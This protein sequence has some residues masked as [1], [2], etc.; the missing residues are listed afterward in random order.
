MHARFGA[1]AHRFTHSVS[2]YAIDLDEGAM[3]DRRTRIFGYE[4][5]AVVSLRARDHFGDANRS[6]RETVTGTLAARGIDIADGRIVVVTNLRTFGYV[7]NPISCFWCWY[8]DGT[9]AAMIA[10][11]SNTFGERH[12]YVLPADEATQRGSAYVWD[13]DKALHVSPFFG[14]NQ[15]YRITAAPPGARLALAIS[16]FEDGRRVLSTSL[17]GTR[18]PFTRRHLLAAQCA[19]PLMPQR[20]TALIHLEALRLYNKGV[21][22]FRKPAFRT[23]YGS[24]ELQSVSTERRGLR[25]P[26]DARRSLMTPIVAR[27]APRSLSHPPIGA[28]EVHYPNG[29]RQRSDSHVPGPTPIIR[30]HSKDVYRRVAARGMT[31]AGEAYVA[32]DWDADDLAGAVELLIRRSHALIGSPLGQ[33][34]TRARDHRPRVPERVSMALARHQIQYHYDLGNDLYELFLD[35]SMTYSCGIFDGPDTDLATAQKNKHR[36]ICTKL[37]L[38]A[39]DHVLEIGCGWGAFAITA[40]GEFGARVTGVTLSEE[41][42]ALATERVRAAGLA[43]RIDLRLVDYRTLDDTFTAIASTE[44]I[45][46]IGHRELPNFFATCDRLLA[47]NGVVCLQAISMPDQRYA[48]YRRSRDWISEYIFPGGNIPSLSAMTQAM[49]TSSQLVVNHVEDIGIHYART[50]ELWRERFDGQRDAVMALGFDEQFLRGW[51]FYL[52]SCEAAFRARSILDYQLVLTRPFNDRLDDPMGA[53]S[54]APAHASI[55]T[56]RQKAM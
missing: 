41:Q 31:G 55:S 28:L 56:P 50:L 15:R 33:L 1:I 5:S 22:F 43:D 26:P 4:R 17:T 27:L 14:M 2:M 52:A 6:M 39:S 20:V 11:V 10:E 7:F 29:T 36:L 32:G 42:H 40:A 46:A 19:T 44:M 8:P 35:E 24:L 48:R 34:L 12:V 30:I 54:R 23:G 9:L 45:E 37:G 25:P 3:L 47:P 18:R 51:R 21:P 13:T 53:A 16:V 49:T 38:S